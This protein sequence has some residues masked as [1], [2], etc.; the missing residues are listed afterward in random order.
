MAS[1][2]VLPVLIGLAVDYAI[3]FQ[4]R[5]DEERGAPGRSPAARAAARGPRR[6]APR[7]SPP[8]AR[9]PRGLPR[10]AALAGAD[11]ARLRPA[12]RD[13]HR[14]RVRLR[15][16]RGLRGDGAGAEGLG[17]RDAG[18]AAPARH[19]ARRRRRAGRRDL[20][21]DAW[22]VAV[23]E[24]RRGTP[25]TAV[26]RRR[27]AAWAIDL[28]RARGRGVA[29]RRAATCRSSRS[30]LGG[31]GGRPSPISCCSQGLTGGTLGTLVAG[32][33]VR[34]AAGGAAGRPR[35]PRC[36]RRRWFPTSSASWRCR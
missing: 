3:Q 30:R 19:G 29:A 20:V 34:A 2:A 27:A 23:G 9:R 11:G 5:F 13:R 8:P 24:P 25:E 12:A 14:A 26:L 16:H 10:A 18:V 7:R 36:A 35:R 15:A 21:A 32:V 1:V 33:R 6:S 22:L 28:A 31:A 4:A 17:P